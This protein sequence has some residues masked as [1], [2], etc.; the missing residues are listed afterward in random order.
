MA[1]AV[2]YSGRAM[3]SSHRLVGEVILLKMDR[4]GLRDA[5][6]RWLGKYQLLV[7]MESLSLL[8][9]GYRERRAASQ[10]DKVERAL[11]DVRPHTHI[12]PEEAHIVRSSSGKPL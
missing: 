10:V 3:S 1:W 5:L 2:L 8:V 11:Q 6:A 4:K 12:T 7:L 9:A